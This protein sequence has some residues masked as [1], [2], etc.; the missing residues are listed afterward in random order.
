[1]D[2]A[3]AKGPNFNFIILMMMVMF[4]FM[5]FTNHQQGLAVKAKDE[6]AKQAEE[7]KKR[8]EAADQ[9]NANLPRP[10][11][12]HDLDLGVATGEVDK[13]N[14][15]KLHASFTNKGA[16]VSQL[17]L[18]HHWNEFRFNNKLAGPID[19]LGNSREIANQ[20]DLKAGLDQSF[21][22]TINDD[23][24]DRRTWEVVEANQKR[25][26]FKAL[27]MGGKLEV[28]KTFKLDEDSDF[29]DL[30]ISLKNLSDAEMPSVSYD[31]NSG[32]AI[33]LEGKW[34][35][36]YHHRVSI[37]QEGSNGYATLREV[38]SA[39]IAGNSERGAA[40]ARF[41]DSPQPPVRYA[42]VA[43]KYFASIIIQ[44]NPTSKQPLIDHVLAKL[45]SLP[46]PKPVGFFA[47]L[48]GF[49]PFRLEHSN[50]QAVLH[51]KPIKL[52]A[53]QTTQHEYRIFN[54][55]KE[56]ELLAKH[57][58]MHLSNLIHYD[59]TF[60]GIF[61]T[62]SNILSPFMLGVLKF[63]RGIFGDY[64]I[65]IIFLTFTVRTLLLPLSIYITKSM[66]KMQ[67][68]QPKLEGLKKQYEGN[69]QDLNK[70]MFELYRKEKV[71]PFGACFM[72]FAQLPIFIS[73]YQALDRSFDLRQS[74][75]F[76]NA[77]WIKDLA[78]PDQLFHFGFDMP[79]LGQSFN[80]LPILATVQSIVQ[81]LYT[82]PK[83]NDP[84]K[85]MQ[86]KMMI[87]MFPPLMMLMFY[88]VPAGLCIYFIT[89]GTWGFI[90]R[91]LLKRW[92]TKQ[93]GSSGVVTSTPIN[94]PVAPKNGKPGSNGVTPKPEHTWL[95]KEKS[96]SRK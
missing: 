64:G 73:L 19:L 26:V 54:G 69:P 5:S 78:A 67:E 91:L 6:A 29:L 7:V 16:A 13:S 17:Q 87:Y 31:L 23:D 9:V 47:Q 76:W 90:E 89:Q 49:R 77:T 75:P 70:A 14:K 72:P 39:E 86:R 52:A 93:Q 21:A 2:K 15:F 41:G 84:E 95:K 68:I 32:N 74:I 92:S 33:P 20:R 18:N 1:M 88:W 55:P 25:V 53:G 66:L 12:R 38:Q 83:T 80:L 79:I 40:P 94:E 60:L 96:K 45:V 62:F 3:P 85:E 4:I 24:L 11:E 28:T 27:T 82:I 50:I 58:D 51:S 35:S 71:N 30:E 59:S 48:M 56:A 37:C 36:T 22:M 43:N 44:K 57:E 65:A 42:G 34:Y 46:A 61:P 81:M 10:A 63:F 8:R